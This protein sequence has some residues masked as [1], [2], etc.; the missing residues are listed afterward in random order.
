MSSTDVSELRQW[1]LLRQLHLADDK[2]LGPFLKANGYPH[3]STQKPWG[4]YY[5]HIR[6]KNIRVTALP[7]SDRLL[8]IEGQI[9]VLEQNLVAQELSQNLVAQNLVAQNLAAQEQVPQERRQSLSD[10]LF[11]LSLVSKR[12]LLAGLRGLNE[13]EQDELLSILIRSKHLV[14]EG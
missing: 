3:D 14:N 13:E 10:Y 9:A 8:Y 12:K 1:T 6:N 7:V 11:S 2:K 5:A 4:K